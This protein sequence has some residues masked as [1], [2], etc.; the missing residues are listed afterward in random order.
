MFL[1]RKNKERNIH[2]PLLLLNHVRIIKFKF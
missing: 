1:K 2:A